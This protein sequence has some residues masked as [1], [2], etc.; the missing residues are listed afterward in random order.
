MDLNEE[1]LA[2]KVT[3]LPAR[4]ARGEIRFDL[5]SVKIITKSQ[6]LCEMRWIR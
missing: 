5:I 1:P 2:T 3:S 6:K 4:Q